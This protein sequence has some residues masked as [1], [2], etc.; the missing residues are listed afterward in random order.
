MVDAQSTVEATSKNHAASNSSNQQTAGD[1][2]HDIV[3]ALQIVEATSENSAATKH[4]K[5]NLASSQK[6]M[7]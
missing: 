7:H 1:V 5:D 4:S 2:H 3:D 6:A